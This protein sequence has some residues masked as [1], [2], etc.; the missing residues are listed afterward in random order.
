MSNRLLKKD[1]SFYSIKKLHTKTN[2]GI[3]YEN[4]YTTINNNKQK[5]ACF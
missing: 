5:K 1:K 3:I 4:D 2:N